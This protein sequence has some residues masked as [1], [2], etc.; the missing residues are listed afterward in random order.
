MNY[1]S[2][3]E[4]KSFSGPEPRRLPEGHE[5]RDLLTDILVEDGLCIA[6]F[7]FGPVALPEEL[8]SK[9][10]GLVGKEAAVLRLDGRYHCRAV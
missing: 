8:E 5:A 10:R 6:F 4:M 1:H 7:K 2:T 9:L 3:P